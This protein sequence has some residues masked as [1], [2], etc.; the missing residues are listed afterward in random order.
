MV[1]ELTHDEALFLREILEEHHR[2]L[3]LELSHTD[4]K[5]FR[6]L[7]RKKENAVQALLSKLEAQERV[8]A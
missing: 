8:A 6:Q 4:H 5:E 7:L 1:L 3:L 2:E